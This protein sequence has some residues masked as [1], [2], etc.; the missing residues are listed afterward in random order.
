VDA[1]NKATSD[2]HGQHDKALKDSRNKIAVETTKAFLNALKFQPNTDINKVRGLKNGILVHDK[3]TGQP[4]HV[5]PNQYLLYRGD[6]KCYFPK[7]DLSEGSASSEIGKSFSGAYGHKNARLNK[8]KTKASDQN[9]NKKQ[10]PIYRGT[11]DPD[12]DDGS[13]GELEGKF[14]NKPVLLSRFEQLP[15]RGIIE[16]IIMKMESKQPMSTLPALTFDADM[17]VPEVTEGDI[18]DAF[19]LNG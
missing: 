13:T 3:D 11:D 10:F 16:D 9:P 1:I 17:M 14:E 2:I 15:S 6:A 12:A 19:R 4:L 5:L 18:E 7:N 8:T